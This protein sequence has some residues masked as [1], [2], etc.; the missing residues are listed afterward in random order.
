[1][2]VCMG[3]ITTPC[4]IGVGDRG[5]RVG[6]AKRTCGGRLRV[7]P[8]SSAV[9]AL[10]KL[11]GYAV[12]SGSLM[13]KLPQVARVYNKKKGQGI[14]MSGIVLETL[15][16]AL[17][18]VYSL[19]SAFP[20]ST[21]GEALFIPLQNLAIMALIIKYERLSAVKWAL[22]LLA[23]LAGTAV[24]MLPAVTIKALAV[25]N[26][27]AN[28]I[29]YFSRVPQL[30]L[31]WKTKSTGEL[32]PST[33]G[34]QLLGNLARIFTTIVQVRD[35]VVLISFVSATFLNGALFFQWWHYRNRTPQPSQ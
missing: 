35:P 19:R 9:E 12:L 30:H 17:A 29:T 22:A 8:R 7:V 26:L 1:M 27:C 5:V 13:Y 28:P 10:S 14:S 11:V 21:F 32:A 2:R 20:F 23:F 33:L 3:F 16:I 31:N 24:L 15:G 34:L 18:G 6:R 25:L 4:R